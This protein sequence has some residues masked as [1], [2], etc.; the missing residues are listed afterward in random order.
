MDFSGRFV[1]GG[2]VVGHVPPGSQ[3][4]VAGQSA[5]VSDRGEFLVGLARDATGKVAI[6]ATAPDGTVERSEAAI[7]PR[8][9][10]IQRI[11]GLPESQVTPP[12]A[13]L[14]RIRA[15]AALVR[16][17]RDRNSA[18]TGFREGFD[19]PVTGP[20]SG[21]FGSQR[22][23]NGE[24]RAFHNGVDVAAPPG[25]VVHAPAAG[26]V[27]LTH[28]GMFFNGKT[29][30]I[31]HG[32]GLTSVYIHMSDIA[33]ANGQRVER[34]DPIGKVGAT[35]RATGPHLHWGVNLFD[36]PLDPALLVPPMPAVDKTTA[37]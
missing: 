31:D 32:H 25:S 4:T 29:V 21:I 12:E 35:G 6:V 10:D 17:A 27:V 13:D 5:R 24:P 33:V 3:V 20:I 19:W 7:E 26:V 2:L 14:A 30:M 8:Q 22:I 23:L 16:A 37:N 34:G 36:V 18:L 9:W 28:P 1:Q 15:E 11:D